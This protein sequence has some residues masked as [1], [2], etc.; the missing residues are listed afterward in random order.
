VFKSLLRRSG[1][2]A[3]ILAII[4]AGGVG[5]AGEASAAPQ[6][7]VMSGLFRMQNCMALAAMYNLTKP[8][9]SLG[10]WCADIGLPPGWARLWRDIP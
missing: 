2:A 10:A 7:I 3:T 1:V 8:R 5:V 9:G 6:R 4:L